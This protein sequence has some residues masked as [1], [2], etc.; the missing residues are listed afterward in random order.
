MV[1]LTGGQPWRRFAHAL[2]SRRSSGLELL[3]A[4][5]LAGSV[6]LGYAE[7][8]GKIELLSRLQLWYE[9]RDLWARG[10]AAPSLRSAGEAASASVGAPSDFHLQRDPFLAATG[11]LGWRFHPFI[12]M[13][14]TFF[15]GDYKPNVRDFFGFRNS[16]NAY[17][18]PGD[19]TYIVMTGNSELAGASHEVSIA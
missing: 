7:G 16:F 1:S 10:S 11:Q 12:D 5:L 17:F 15:M 14:G 18:E 6:A 19:Y 9:A 4:V 8:G 2:R 3:L 13:A